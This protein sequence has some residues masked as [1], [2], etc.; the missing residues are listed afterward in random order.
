[1]LPFNTGECCI[2]AAGCCDMSP[3]QR[4]PGGPALHVHWLP[5][6]LPPT[7]LHPGSSGRCQASWVQECRVGAHSKPHIELL[8]T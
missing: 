5:T 2:G 3:C 1:M 4:L 7:K 6:C 8:S